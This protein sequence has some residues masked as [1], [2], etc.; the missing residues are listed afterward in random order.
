MEKWLALLEKISPILVHYP[1]AVQW[2]FILSLALVLTSVFAFTVG[3]S[4]AA[5]TRDGMTSDGSLPSLIKLARKPSSGRDAAKYVIESASMIVRLTSRLRADG[6]KQTS[7]ADARIT[8]TVFALDDV[9]P[10]EFDEFAHTNMSGAYVAW[11]PGSDKE[12]VEET[13]DAKTWKIDVPILKGHRRSFTTA[14][15]YVYPKDFQQTRE[16]HDFHE[17]HPDEDAF[18]Y[19]NEK[20]VIGE[21][22]IRIESDVPLS[23]PIQGDGLLYDKVDK[24][25]VK[26]FTPSL[27]QSDSNSKGITLYVAVARWE[28]VIQKQVAELRIHRKT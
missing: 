4:D 5:K 7:E 17:L 1:T 2:L 3:Y 28:K 6:M 22:T 23:N 11:L 9:Q 13:G 8:Y 20:D 15:R 25:I 19:P 12:N 18:A 14:M 10:N 21:L 26:G 24:Q 16:V 27:Y